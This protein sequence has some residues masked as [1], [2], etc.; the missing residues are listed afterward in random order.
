[1]KDTKMVSVNRASVKFCLP[2]SPSSPD[3]KEEKEKRE[4]YEQTGGRRRGTRRR[5]R[6]RTKAGKTPS[7]V[8]QKSPVKADRAAL[9]RLSVAATQEEE[10]KKEEEE[11]ET[12]EKS[13]QLRTTHSH[14]RTYAANR[15]VFT[16][17]DFSVEKDGTPGRNVD[18]GRKIDMKKGK[19]GVK[20]RDV[21]C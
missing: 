20:G 7:Q 13:D 11:V 14:E 18:F 19:S 4:K 1:M 16:K 12:K 10:E 8:G 2:S 21:R 6:R 5:R 3:R 15:R 17:S 9:Y